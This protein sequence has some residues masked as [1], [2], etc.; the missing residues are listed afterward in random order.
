MCKKALETD[1]FLHRGPLESMRG[2]EFY[3][4]RQMK[5]GAQQCFKH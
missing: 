2:G 1:I 3:F 5:E 4:V